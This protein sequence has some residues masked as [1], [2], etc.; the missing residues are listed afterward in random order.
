MKTSFNQGFDI[1]KYYHFPQ[2]FFLSFF[3]SSF[4]GLI[5]QKKKKQEGRT[6]EEGRRGGTDR[7]GGVG[8]E[9]EGKRK[10]HKS[11]DFLLRMNY[12]VVVGEFLNSTS[13][14]EK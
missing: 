12:F 13:N 6:K 9:R 5:C 8:A 7:Y 11:E 2:P 10:P 14:S 3:F 1:C 4:L